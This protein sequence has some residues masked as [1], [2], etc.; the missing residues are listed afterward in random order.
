MKA[1]KK[2]TVLAAGAAAFVIPATS[3]SAAELEQGVPET[4]QEEV[5]RQEETVYGQAGTLEE[6]EKELEGASEAL[7]QAEE[8][9]DQAQESYDEADQAA[10]EAG[11]VLEDAKEEESAAVQEAQDSFENAVADAEQEAADLEA[12]DLEAAVEGSEQDMDTD[13]IPTNRPVLRNDREDVMFVSREAKFRAIVKEVKRA[14]A[15]GQP[16]LIGTG[17]V[18]D[19]EILSEYFRRGR[20]PH[21]VLNAKRHAYEARIVAQAGRYGAVTIATN[22]AGR[23]TDI[24]LDRKAKA[25]GGLKVIGT[26]RAESRRIDDQLIGRAGRQGDP[27][28]S[29]FFLSLEDPLFKQYGAE[30]EAAAIRAQARAPYRKIRSRRIRSFVKKAQKKAEGVRY[31]ERKSVRE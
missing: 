12:A 1:F 15:K 31:M 6:A 7:D 20:I 29:V 18:E 13:R 23:G 4:S 8:E 22:M 17:S 5:L 30:K 16:V 9:L 27:G 26:G 21:S 25:A 2:A 19:S 24:K 11:Q 28:E 14:Q 3:V 10:E